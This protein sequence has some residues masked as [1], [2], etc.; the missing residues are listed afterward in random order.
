MK[1]GTKLNRNYDCWKAHEP[2]DLSRAY[3][4]GY[5]DTAWYR[6]KQRVIAHHFCLMF[7]VAWYEQKAGETIIRLPREVWH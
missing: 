5:S 4:Q 7:R 1:C 6:K 3:E 2:D